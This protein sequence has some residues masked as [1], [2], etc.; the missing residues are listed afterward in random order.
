[1]SQ[2][3]L[4]NLTPEQKKLVAEKNPMARV[5]GY[6]DGE[7]KCKKC[8]F[9]SYRQPGNKKYFKCKKRGISRGAGTDHRVNWLACKLYEKVK[10]ERC[11]DLGKKYHHTDWDTRK[12]IYIPCT[13]CQGERK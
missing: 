3:E 8:R 9:M 13:E 1:M 10:C 7:T 5:Q 6:F 4:F 12:S 2:P 11:W